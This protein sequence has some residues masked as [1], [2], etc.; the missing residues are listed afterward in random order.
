MFTGNNDPQHNPQWIC[1]LWFSILLPLM[2]LMLLMPA[3]GQSTFGSVLGTVKD[4]SGSVVQKATVKLINIDENTSRTL[5]IS[6]SFESQKIINLPANYRGAGGSTSPY[7]L[8]AAL[9]GV[10]SE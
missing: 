5:T 2:L 6:S 1:A 4:A 7:A 3:H 10:Q 9:P 8:I